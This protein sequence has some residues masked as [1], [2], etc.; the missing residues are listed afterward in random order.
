MECKR[1][2]TILKQQTNV[3]ENRLE[4]GHEFAGFEFVGVE[5]IGA[6]FGARFGV[7]EAVR[8]RN[9]QQSVALQDARA[10]LEEGA[11]VGQMFDD[12]ESDH[13]VKGVRCKR[14]GASRGKGEWDA[15]L[16]KVRLRV[17]D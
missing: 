14:H 11:L 10:L 2:D 16:Q 13:Q 7:V 6:S 1:L 12:F 9:D 17:V 15:G 4:F 3:A 8:R 5:G